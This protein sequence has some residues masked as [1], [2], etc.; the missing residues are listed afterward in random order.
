[1]GAGGG[2]R[3]KEGPAGAGGAPRKGM[4]ASVR[5]ERKFHYPCIAKF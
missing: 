5:S 3:G 4:G 1:M 2:G